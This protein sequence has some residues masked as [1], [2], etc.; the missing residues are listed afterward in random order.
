MK[1]KIENQE[2]KDYLIHIATS[3]LQDCS[4]FT[5]I[6]GKRF[7]ANRLKTNLC[8]VYTN[9]ISKKYDGYAITKGKGA[10]TITIFCKKETNEPL[11]VEQIEEN[12]DLKAVLLHEA[13]HVILER[14][15]QE[16]AKTLIKSGTGMLEIHKDFEIGRGLNEGLTNWIV[17]K[18]GLYTNSYQTLTNFMEELEL[19]IGEEDVMALGKGNIL[20]KVP[21][22]L[23]MDLVECLRIIG[24]GDEIYKLN[25]QITNDKIILD[26][27]KRY[28]RRDDLDPE[29]REEAEKQYKELLQTEAKEES[30]YKTFLQEENKSDTPE[31]RR[32]FFEKQLEE[33]TL[34]HLKLK[35]KFESIIYEKYFENEFE[36]FIKSGM[37]PNLQQL[38]KWEDLWS[39]ITEEGV[40]E[41][42]P[43]SKFK[44]KYEEIREQYLNN[45]T[46][47]AKEEFNNGKLSG[48]KLVE[49]LKKSSGFGC[50][51]SNTR[52]LSTV[53]N[54]MEP[55]SI[56]A[57][58]IQDLLASLD[59]EQL[60]NI[61]KYK[62]SISTYCAGDTNIPVYI[63]NG[64]IVSAFLA[65][66]RGAFPQMRITSEKE[67]KDENVMVFDYT[68]DLEE[69]GYI[70]AREEALQ[71]YQKALSLD[72]STKMKIL[73]RMIVLENKDGTQTPYI[74]SAGHVLP[75]VQ[76]KGST[77]NIRLAPNPVELPTVQSENI[78]SKFIIGIKRKF[79]KN[80]EGDIYYNTATSEKSKAFRESMR[81][82]EVKEDLETNG[83]TTQ[84]EI[85]ILGEDDGLSK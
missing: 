42:I 8:K 17:R 49:L 43:I 57:S 76:Q 55:H 18:T 60:K 35:T 31:N 29:D 16:C 67:L 37:E 51:R 34:R 30:E 28:L 50:D 11:S 23:K 70:T 4:A 1:E 83:S 85:K 10:S 58:Y 81:F 22:L 6:F 38:S 72:P 53:A 63:K 77:T 45:I 69:E 80:P 74:I 44:E 75:A 7:A 59:F 68:A 2:I 48:N 52:L 24:I 27:T 79:S 46:I 82:G 5:K 36:Q 62:M 15:K 66:S 32:D 61:N 14:T 19:A 71:I 84:N 13:I 65:Y 54:L 64:K 41:D 40:Q 9:E 26:I 39:L 12:E 56:N 3:R 73:D 47:K 78:L 33:K 21:I 25:D 20:K